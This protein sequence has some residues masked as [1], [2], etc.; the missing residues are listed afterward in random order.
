MTD[1]E[2]IF[3]A[4]IIGVL[5]GLAIQNYIQSFHDCSDIHRRDG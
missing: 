4:V 1:G 2:T 3:W 5:I